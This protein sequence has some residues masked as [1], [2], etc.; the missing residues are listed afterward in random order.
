[1]SE[2]IKMT[3]AQ[4]ERLIEMLLEFIEKVTV[5]GRAN[6]SE[7]SVLPAVVEVLCKYFKGMS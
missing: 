5:S 6:A 7:V 1:M 4:Q 2:I 3:E